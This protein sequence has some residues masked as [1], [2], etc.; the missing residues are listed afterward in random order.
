MLPFF[1]PFPELLLL[2]SCTETTKLR[3]TLFEKK[4]FFLIGPYLPAVAVPPAAERSRPAVG[5]RRGG[6]TQQQDGG[7][8][9]EE[10]GRGVNQ[11]YRKKVS[12]GFQFTIFLA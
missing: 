6:G 12:S 1:P 4:G 10:K 7:G 2:L 3:F 8:E 9:G 11:I 5:F